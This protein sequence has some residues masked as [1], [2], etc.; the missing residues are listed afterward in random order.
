VAFTI[1]RKPAILP[2]CEARQHQPAL[3]S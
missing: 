3:R 1:S 2:A